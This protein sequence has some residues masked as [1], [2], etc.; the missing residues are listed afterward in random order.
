MWTKESKTDEK[1]DCLFDFAGAASALCGNLN[2]PGAE[3]TAL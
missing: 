3:R 1:S 2:A